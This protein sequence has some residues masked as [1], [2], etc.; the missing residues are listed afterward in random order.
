MRILLVNKFHWPKGGS[1]TYYFELGKMLKEHGHE[2]AYFSM[3]NKNNITTGD[4]EYFVKEF[5]GNGKNIFKFFD[6]IYSRE[7]KKK[8]EQ[9]LDDF[10]PDI[11]HIN[12]FQRHL[13]FSI[14][15]PI[16]KRNIPIVYT[17]HDLQ[18]VCPASAM[19]SNGKVCNKCL[20]SNK[21]H[22][23]T[24]KCVKNSTLKSLLCSIEATIY[25][26][27]HIYDKF[28]LI[29]SPSSFVGN[30]IKKDGIKSNIKVLHNYVDVD[31]KSDEYNDE[32]Y[33]F[34][35]GRLSIDKGIMN[36]LE[37]FS[38]QAEGKL[39][40]AG[41]GPEKEKILKYIK[42]NNLNDRVKL[43]G[44]VKHKQ[45]LEY[46]KNSSFVIV[47][48]ICYD[49]CPFSVLESLS[50]GKCVIGAE[51]GG[52][53]ELIENGKNGYLYQ[54]DNI[55]QLSEII[56]KM[57]KNKNLRKKMSLYSLKYDRPKYSKENYYAEL[58]KIYNSLVDGKN[59]S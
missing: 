4:K 45:I 13:T 39:L 23:L 40:I 16:K 12:L 42:T 29:I 53:P 11:V 36:L 15:N 55:T 30:I 32:N 18:S 58:E 37:A 14:I 3:Q 7:N 31:N 34:Y 25:K 1:E 9:A 5:D 22:C 47:P 56:S 41:D 20:N 46:I 17:A 35:F 6:A 33:A 50:V 54:H 44:F 51:I 10:K 24:K 28:N 43:V 19:L 48:S 57:F 49:N 27:K 2:V 38:K 59:V 8:M 21:F 52:I 26:R